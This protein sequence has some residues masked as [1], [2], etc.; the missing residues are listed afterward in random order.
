MMVQNGMPNAAMIRK[1]PGSVLER[2]I[3]EVSR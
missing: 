2:P 3:S 1:S